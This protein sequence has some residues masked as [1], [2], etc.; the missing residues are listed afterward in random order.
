MP[1]PEVWETFFAPE[2]ALDLFGCDRVVGDAV[3]LGCGYGTFSLPAARRIGGVLHAFDVDPAALAVLR[4]Q[5][6][7]SG[8]GNL[9]LHERDFIAEGTSLPDGSVDF[10]MLFNILHGEEPETLLREARRIL[11]PGAVAAVMHWRSD[12]PTPRGPDLAIRP[13]PEQVA[14][15]AQAA[16]LEAG[17]AAI[18]IEPFHFGLRLVRR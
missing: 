8:I 9:Q 6:K 14:I 17:R 7:R 15:W 3:D 16:G 4:V 2:R 13:R 12:V 11:R 18:V 1:D 5:A 10:V